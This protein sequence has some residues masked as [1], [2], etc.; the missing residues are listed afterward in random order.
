[1][2]GSV[3]EYLK[4]IKCLKKL[5]IILKNLEYHLNWFLNNNW[6]GDSFQ[7]KLILVYP[8]GKGR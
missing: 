4:K 1:M 6:V 2:Y 3:F 8:K 5:K 7:I